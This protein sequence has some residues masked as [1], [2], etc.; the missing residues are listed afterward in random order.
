MCLKKQD[1]PK[2]LLLKYLIKCQHLMH[3]RTFYYFSFFFNFY[4]NCTLLNNIVIS[5]SI[6]LYSRFYHSKRDISLIKYDML[7]N[8]LQCAY[9]L[10][11]QSHFIL[12]YLHI[13]LLSVDLYL[14]VIN[15]AFKKLYGV[16]L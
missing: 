3:L 11:G 6:K 14:I 1:S 8:E 13:D 10:L 7:F 2:V 12:R 5:F 9:C 15:C 16:Y 4:L